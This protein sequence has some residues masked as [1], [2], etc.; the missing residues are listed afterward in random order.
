MAYRK[1]GAPHVSDGTSRRVR[2]LKRWPAVLGALFVGLLLAICGDAVV[3]WLCPPSVGRPFPFS[4]RPKGSIVEVIAIDH[5]D[6]PLTGLTSQSWAWTDVRILDD[7]PEALRALLGARSSDS[8]RSLRGVEL[9]R[10]Y[11]ALP[12]LGLPVELSATRFGFPFR[13]SVREVV[14][15]VVPVEATSGGDLAYALSEQLEVEVTALRRWV[16]DPHRIRDE[17]GDVRSSSQRDFVRPLALLGNT[18]FFGSGA[19]LLAAIPRRVLDH[20]RARSGR[21]TS[22]GHHLGGRVG[23]RCPECGN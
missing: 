23:R 7:Q 16:S 22:C 20:L 1:L 11:K 4:Y 13:S 15:G 17:D 8:V 18:I 6:R 14:C 19:L 2:P 12:N 10:R 3:R 5:W 9:T 21:C